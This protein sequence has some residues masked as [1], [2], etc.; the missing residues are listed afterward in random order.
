MNYDF[1]K[2]NVNFILLLACTSVLKY[3]LDHPKQKGPWVKARPM[4]SELYENDPVR[5]ILGV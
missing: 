2:K 1:F 3:L 5:A 4:G